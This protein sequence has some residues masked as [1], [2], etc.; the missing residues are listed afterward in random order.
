MAS[1]TLLG[2]T[3]RFASGTPALQDLTLEV[4]DGEFLVLLGPSGC[5]KTT[6]LRCIAGLEEPTAGEIRIGP[7]DVT[8]LPPGARDVAMVFQNY[9]LYPHLT[10]RENI[11]L[12]LEMRRTPEAEVVRRVRQAADRLGLGDLLDRR[13]AE[14]SGGQR[15]RVALGR[16]IVRQPRVF[17]F[18]EP[19]SNLDAR[20]RVE[21]RAE[22]L[23]LHRDL[24]ATMIFVTHDQIEAMTMG[25]RIAVLHEGR[26]R[27]VGAPADVYRSP[28][29]AFVAAFVGSPGM[30]ILAGAPE[31]ERK[32]VVGC[33]SLRF[34]MPMNIVGPVQIGI[35]PE[36]LTLAEPGG[37]VGDADVR[38][39]EPLGSDTLVHLDAG[40]S[41][42]V[43]KVPGIP[44]L[45]PGTR[46]GV[47]VDPANVHLFDAGGA[48]IG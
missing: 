18:D 5:G 21:M 43:A 3:K 38:M 22:L 34:R 1:V 12:P 25:Q 48:R 40:G 27:Q 14:L 36:H 28:A 4:S 44:A 16:A 23:T 20:L 17:L 31:P 33:G 6:A 10:V 35:R 19:L 15:Q 30:N 47:Q 42:L 13:P 46:V 24:G 41:R 26:L 9:A 2:L 7:R 8:H 29:V 11:A 45:A 37:G 39:V 32:R